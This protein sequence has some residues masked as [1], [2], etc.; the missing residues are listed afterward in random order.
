MPT[1]NAKQ[2]RCQNEL[3]RILPKRNGYLGAGLQAH[4]QT[5][6]FQVVL[7][8]LNFSFRRIDV[9]NTEQIAREEI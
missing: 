1:R 8:K 9:W 6:L 2:F 3:I 7:I 5:L 4:W